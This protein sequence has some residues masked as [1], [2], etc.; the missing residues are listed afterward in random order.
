MI[1]VL[2]TLREKYFSILFF[3]FFAKDVFHYFFDKYFFAFRRTSF[4]FHPTFTFFSVCCFFFTYSCGFAFIS[5]TLSFQLAILGEILLIF[6][7][8]P[9]YCYLNSLIFIQATWHFWSCYVSNLCNFVYCKI[10]VISMKCKQHNLIQIGNAYIDLKYNYTALLLHCYEHLELQ[11]KNNC[12]LL[13]GMLQ[14]RGWYMPCF[15]YWNY[16]FSKNYFFR[17]NLFFIIFKANIKSFNNPSLFLRNICYQCSFVDLKW[18]IFVN[19][20]KRWNTKNEGKSVVFG[21][22]FWLNTR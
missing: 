10:S 20:Y 15:I 21:M 1:L 16:M 12:L 2:T 4:F 22:K 11:C 13:Y 14:S 17:I 7:M 8:Q 3:L 5:L 6:S 9:F 18:H 19:E